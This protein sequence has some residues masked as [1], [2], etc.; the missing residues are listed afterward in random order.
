MALTIHTLGASTFHQQERAVIFLDVYSSGP[1]QST[2]SQEVTS[3]SNELQSLLRE[4][5]PKTASGDAAPTAAV[6]HWS[7]SSLGTGS[8]MPWD[9]HKQRQGERVFT[10]QTSFQIKFR[11]FSKLGEYASEVA[12]V[13]HVSVRRI[14]WRLTDQTKAHLGQLCRKKAVED[15]VAKAADYADVLG[16]RNVR[17]VEVNDAG[18]GGVAPSPPGGYI[19]RA[20]RPFEFGSSTHQ[21]ESLSFTPKN[22]EVQCSVKVRFEAE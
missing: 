7:M 17:D 8:H 4:L 11:D 18:I 19:T 1:T 22:C 2:V 21:E 12:G 14:D 16:R 3:L 20:V 6:T 9:T 5:A 10:A 15:A 13:P